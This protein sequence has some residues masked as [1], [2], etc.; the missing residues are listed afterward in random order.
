MNYLDANHLLERKNYNLVSS[1]TDQLDFWT[2]PKKG[3]SRLAKT[4]ADYLKNGK[5]ARFAVLS[6]AL[7]VIISV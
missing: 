5:C 4:I 2:Q 7:S 6:G 1:G 3:V